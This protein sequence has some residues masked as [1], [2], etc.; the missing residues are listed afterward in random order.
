VVTHKKKIKKPAP[1]RALPSPSS[2][3][4]VSADIGL[5]FNISVTA[6]SRRTIQTCR[7][8]CAILSR[9]IMPMNATVPGCCWATM[10]PIAL[11]IRV[12]NLPDR[13]HAGPGHRL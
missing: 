4:K 1:A 9:A 2:C 10:L 7:V 11:V 5:C 12:R 3:G 8:A 6:M 13:P